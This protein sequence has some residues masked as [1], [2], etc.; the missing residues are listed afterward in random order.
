[1]HRYESLIICPI[2]FLFY[3]L[4]TSH[5]VIVVSILYSSIYS[6]L[7]LLFKKLSQIKTPSG[8]G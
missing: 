7:I 3:Y 1:M 6:P 5:I 8:H 2:S 4:F